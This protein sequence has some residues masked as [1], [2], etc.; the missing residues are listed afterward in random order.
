MKIICKS[1]FDLDYINDR[2][3]C[4]NINTYYGEKLVDFLNK[5]LSGDNSHDFYVLVEDDYTL[6][7]FEI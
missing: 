4:E 2:L 3:V 7:N 5:T 6:Y 1:N